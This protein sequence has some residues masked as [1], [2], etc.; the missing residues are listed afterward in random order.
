MPTY[1]IP[2]ECI[3]QSKI[4]CLIN[5]WGLARITI[6]LLLLLVLLKWC[7]HA[8]VERVCYTRQFT[9]SKKLLKCLT[10]YIYIYIQYT[11]AYV[12]R[13]YMLYNIQLE[14]GILHSGEDIYCIRA[15]FRTN[16]YMYIIIYIY[17]GKY[18]ILCVCE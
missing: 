16:T 2:L 6:L 15:F 8:F 11:L 4:V 9:H 17:A 18:N 13:N 12:T 10:V 5:G 7:T 14:L 1:I 3:H